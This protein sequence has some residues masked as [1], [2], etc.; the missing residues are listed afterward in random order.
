MHSFLSTYQDVPQPPENVKAVNV[1]KNVKVTFQPGFNSYSPIQT[2]TVQF[3]VIDP[4]DKVNFLDSDIASEEGPT[5]WVPVVI[6]FN[7]HLQAFR[8]F[9]PKNF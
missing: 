4:D 1:G 5:I 8:Y 6:N 7:L 2:Y 3:A 9:Y